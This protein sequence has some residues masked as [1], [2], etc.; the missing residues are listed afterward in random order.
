MQC[1]YLSRADIESL[2]LSMG[3]IVEALD[4]VFRLKGAGKTEMPP[5][6]GVHTAPNAFI[7]AMPASVQGVATGL[8]WVSGY[9]SNIAKG[10]PY[11]TGLLILNDPDTGVPIAV[12]DCSWITAMRTGASAAIWRIFSCQT[13]QQRR[14][15]SRLRRAGES[16]PYRLARSAA[17]AAP[18]TLL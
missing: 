8:K 9:P 13:R 3:D 11:I 2:N 6:M 15:V 17:V 7:H 16:K 5:K 14:R 10:L 4:G 12:M 18:G 1:T